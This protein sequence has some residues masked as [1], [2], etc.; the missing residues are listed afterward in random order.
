MLNK[1]QDEIKE[2]LTQRAYL[3]TLTGGIDFGAKQVVGF[4]LNPIVISTLG[5]KFY[6]V[7]KILS[8]LN[9]YMMS[10]DINVAQPLKLFIARYRTTT[11]QNNLQNVFSASFFTTLL[12]LPLYLIVGF[13]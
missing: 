6:G 4:I 5:L 10:A 8:Q 7:W 3:N 2:N 12:F 13:F 11:D 1:S 9:N